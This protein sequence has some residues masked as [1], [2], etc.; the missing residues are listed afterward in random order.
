MRKFL[1]ALLLL[2]AGAYAAFRWLPFNNPELVKLLNALQHPVSPDQQRARS[3]RDA[4]VHLA[5]LTQ[6]ALLLTLATGDLRKAL[7]QALASRFASGDATLSAIK[8]ET[9]QQDLVLT[10]TFDVSAPSHH[11]NVRGIATVHGAPA[12][13]DDEIVVRPALSWLSVES[14][15]YL[16][17]ED[18][19]VLVPVLNR[20]L[21][22]MLNNLNGA[23]DAQRVPISV[24]VFQQLSLQKLLAGLP[25]VTHAEG[26]DIAA[27]V[28]VGRSALLIDAEG[29]HVLGELAALDPVGLGTA[30]QRLSAAPAPGSA[31]DLTTEDL[32]VLSACR[33]DAVATFPAALRNALQPACDRRQAAASVA[34]TGTGDPSGASQGVAGTNDNP[35][36]LFGTFSAAF[37]EKAGSL[38]ADAGDWKHT[39]M[40]VSR[41]FLAGVVNK[42][43]GGAVVAASLAID[44]YSAEIPQDSKTIR[45]PPATNLNCDQAGGACPSVFE[46]PPY[47][48]KGCPGDCCNG[49]ADIPFVGRTCTSV[50]LQCATWKP[51]CEAQKESERLAYEA[52]KAGALTAWQAGKIA[53]EAVKAGKIGGCKANQVWLDSVANADVGEVN[54]RITVK[55]IAVQAR[56]GHLNVGQS[57]ETLALQTGVSAAADVEGNVTF[58]P[59]NAGTLVCIAQ[60]SANPTAK[61]SAQMRE[62]SITAALS[63]ATVQKGVLYL[64]YMLPPRNVT[65]RFDAPPVKAFLEQK[66]TELVLKCP[67]VALTAAALAGFAPVGA[68][69]AVTLEQHILKDTFD[70]SLPLGEVAIPIGPIDISLGESHKGKLTGELRPATIVFWFDSVAS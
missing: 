13:I 31:A 70:V 14:V 47:Q 15:R 11:A 18:E 45:L 26:S 64:R 60:W 9:V 22:A 57:F 38:V 43:F 52:A 28:G 8:I 39:H 69:A 36:A 3:L 21:Q 44:P 55:N 35:A 42:T 29:V 68:V 16:G 53:C 4:S 41:S 20:T 37:K 46:Y 40:A 24:G 48:P 23:M 1:F 12:V 63:G 25:N 32:A 34:A 19:S 6:P 27:F 50:D 62:E 65:V 10:V 56:A 66:G 7:D 2:A 58:V 33:Q 67:I 54:G 51:V 17:R 30:V 5:K 59:H 49:H 61:V